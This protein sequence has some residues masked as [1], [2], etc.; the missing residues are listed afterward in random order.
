M[1]LYL[2][3]TLISVTKSHLEDVSQVFQPMFLSGGML[4]GQVIG[5]LGTE[6]HTVQNWVKRGFVDSPVKKLYDQDRFVRLALLNYFKDVFSLEGIIKLLKMA[7]QD[8]IVYSALCSL[9]AHSPV[10]PIRSE[11]KFN[12][13]IDNAIS[14]HDFNYKKTSREQVR[15]LMTILYTAHLSIIL[16]KEAERMAQD[17]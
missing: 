9:L 17:I 16:K 5:L 11:T 7:D 8:S 15:R 2:P 14:S 3:G 6:A 4:L 10:D 1:E 13:I 12:E